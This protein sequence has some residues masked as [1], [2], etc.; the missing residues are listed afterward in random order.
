MNCAYVLG[1]RRIVLVGVDLYD[2]RYFFLPA[3][4]TLGVDPVTGRTTAVGANQWRGNRSSQPH[5]TVQI[6]IVD[7]MK[8]WRS[9][10]AGDGVELYVYNPRSLLADVLPV[11]GDAHRILTLA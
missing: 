9:I 1:W 3:D 11:Y 10:L 7:V 8:S 5:N 2:S 4:K 6:G